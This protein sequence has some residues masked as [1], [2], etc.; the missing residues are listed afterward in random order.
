[1]SENSPTEILEMALE[2]IKTHNQKGNQRIIAYYDESFEIPD[3][4][5]E[6]DTAPHI[7]LI[8]DGIEL[9]N[10]GHEIVE[11]RRYSISNPKINAEL[12]LYGVGIERLLT[13]IYLKLETEKFIQKIKKYGESPGFNTVKESVLNDVY[14]KVDRDAGGIVKLALDIIQ[15][16]RNNEVHLGYHRSTYRD[17]GPL[18]FEVAIGLGYLYLEEVPKTWEEMMEKFADYFDSDSGFYSQNI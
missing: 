5:Q 18:I 8:E 7:S 1:M 11:G 12:I 14:K 13:G 9:V 15:E 16:I 2:G 3:N 17:T 4:I 6:P 10:L